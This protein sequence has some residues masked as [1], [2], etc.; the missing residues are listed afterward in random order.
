MIITEIRFR[1]HRGIDFYQKNSW[2]KFVLISQIRFQ[3]KKRPIRFLNQ[4]ISCLNNAVRDPAA[5]KGDLYV[6]KGDL[7][8][9]EDDLYDSKDDLQRRKGGLQQRKGDLILL[10]EML[11]SPQCMVIQNKKCTFAPEIAALTRLFHSARAP[12]FHSRPI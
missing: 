3:E 11:F 8:R 7:Q 1:N 4:T 6:S 2:T 12:D 10:E 9:R 5:R